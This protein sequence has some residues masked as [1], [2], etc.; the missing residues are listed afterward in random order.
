M[1]LTGLSNVL[2]IMQTLMVGLDARNT[3]SFV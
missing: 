2:K 3:G 1:S